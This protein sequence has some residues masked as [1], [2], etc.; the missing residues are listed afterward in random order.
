MGA[1]VT[2]ATAKIIIKI[3]N[4]IDFTGT[5][6][7]Q[8]ITG[9]DSIHQGQTGVQGVTGLHGTTGLQGA[10][11]AYGGPQ[12]ETGVTG[13]TGV[14]GPIMSVTKHGS[15]QVDADAAPGEFWWTQGHPD[16]PDGVVMIGI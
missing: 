15:S 1:A 9:L 10:T 12:G 16:L 7:I 14:Q 8:G 5:T 13:E 6:G 3:V 2:R 11:G 4:P